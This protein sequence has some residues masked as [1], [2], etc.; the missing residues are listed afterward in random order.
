MRSIIVLLMTALVVLSGCGQDEKAPAANPENPEVE[1]QEEQTDEPVIDEV[2]EEPVVETEEPK[3]PSV[4][5]LTYKPAA[6]TEKVFVQDEEFEITYQI[7]AANETHLQQLIMSGDMVSLQILEWTPTEVSVVYE[8]ENPSDTTDQ[9]DSFKA[10]NAPSTIF[11]V[12]KVGK[13]EG[14]IWE[15]IDGNEQVVVPAGTYDNVYVVQ[16]TTTASTTDS[17]TINQAFYAPE[18]GLIK[19]TIEVTG[20]NGYEATTVLT[21]I[22]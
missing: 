21:E 13:G 10:L 3:E 8:E 18:I 16:R 4:S 5:L 14:N 1:D 11:D 22:K 19:E 9:L 17:K 2:E 20:E 6:D 7:I 12:N 15:V